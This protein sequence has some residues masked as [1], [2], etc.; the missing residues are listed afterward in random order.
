M[1]NEELKAWCAST[2]HL[3]GYGLADGK[4][5]L[6]SV[7][8]ERSGFTYREGIPP[9]YMSRTGKKA[10]RSDVNGIGRMMSQAGFFNSAGGYYTFDSDVAEAIGGYPYGA[11]LRWKDPESGKIRVVR[12]LK[13]DNKDDF[14]SDP[15]L[16]DGASWDFVDNNLPVSIRPRVFPLWDLCNPGFDSGT[17]GWLSFGDT[18][19]ATRPGML[20]L[21]AG[22][23]DD[24]SVAAGDS[25]VIVWADVRM[26]GDEDF[27]SAGMLAYIPP[28]DNAF[29]VNSMSS[30]FVDGDLE[31]KTGYTAKYVAGY[32]TLWLLPGATVRISANQEF[33]FR[34][35]MMF[36]PLAASDEMGGNNVI[37]GGGGGGSDEP[38]PEP[39]DP[40]IVTVPHAM[41]VFPAAALLTNMQLYDQTT[42]VASVVSATASLTFVLPPRVANVSREFEV[43]VDV[44]SGI[45]PPQLVFLPSGGEGVAMFPVDGDYSLFVPQ[46]GMNVFKFREID[47]GSF[48]VSRS[49]AV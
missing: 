8:S 1:T 35:R 27:H 20:L 6:S 18:F 7:G 32:V 13:A 30:M 5:E 14:V 38:S 33:S 11:I 3:F 47:T 17:G 22:A 39:V 10:V 37:P 28:V 43:V 36:V 46:E 25:E 42:H 9:M 49:L 26:A 4:G 12:S 15:G 45:V 48:L 41:R 19:T 34:S 23:D 31:S 24:E 16:I 29:A 44:G 40:T 21:Q 2:A